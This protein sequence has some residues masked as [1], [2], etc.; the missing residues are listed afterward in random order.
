MKKAG[1]AATI[2]RAQGVYS[3]IEDVKSSIEEVRS[4]LGRMTVRVM[5][6]EAEFANLLRKVEHG[7]TDATCEDCAKKHAEQRRF[8]REYSDRLFTRPRNG[9]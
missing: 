3:S 4:V 9:G 2:S 5:F 7:C 1:K 6:V 8:I